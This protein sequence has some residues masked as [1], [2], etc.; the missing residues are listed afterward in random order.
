MKE[1]T[2]VAQEARVQ[3]AAAAREAGPALQQAKQSEAQVRCSTPP[4][5]YLSTS[6]VVSLSS[7]S[8]V[9]L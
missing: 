3:A 4:L 5:A 2:G 6:L 1:L 7:S 9:L 8:V